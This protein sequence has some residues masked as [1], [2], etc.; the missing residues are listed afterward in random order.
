MMKRSAIKALFSANNRQHAFSPRK[1]RR[2][3]A[4]VQQS[5]R[6]QSEIPRLLCSARNGTGWDEEVQRS[7][8]ELRQSHRARLKARDCK[9]LNRYS[10]PLTKEI[11]STTCK[12][13]TKRLQAL[14]KRS[15]LTLTMLRH[16]SVRG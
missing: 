8:L 2:C 3:T 1:V 9:Y 13:S 6:D 12:D 10:L 14:R 4:A 15:K 7:A 5:C 16:T 11:P